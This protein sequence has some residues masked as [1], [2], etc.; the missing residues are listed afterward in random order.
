MDNQRQPQVGRWQRRLLMMTM[1]A[2]VVLLALWIA[3]V[4]FAVA[5]GGVEAWWWGTP[6]LGLV[7]SLILIGTGWNYHRALSK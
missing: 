6:I 3:W 4:A 5:A 7:T 2:G 1:P